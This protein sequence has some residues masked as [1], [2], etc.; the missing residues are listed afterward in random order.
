MIAEIAKDMRSFLLIV[1]FTIIG[2]SL[3]F[4]QFAS[5]T[6]DFGQFMLEQYLYLYGNQP[7]T[8]DFDTSQIIFFIIITLFLAL[9]LTNMLIALM[10]D[11]YNRVDGSSMMAD[12]LEKISLILEYATLKRQVLKFLRICFKRRL[13]NTSHKTR[14]ILL[15]VEEYR[16]GGSSLISEGGRLTVLEKKIDKL[17]QN[18]L[19]GIHEKM[20]D[21]IEQLDARLTRNV[22]EIRTDN[23][24]LLKNFDRIQ[25]LDQLDKLDNLKRLDTLPK[26][27]TLQKL[28]KLDKLDKIEK[29]DKID[30]LDKITNRFD[31]LDSIKNLDK[32]EKLSKLDKLDSLNR[33]DSLKRLDSLS[34]LDRLDQLDKLS[35]LSRLEKLDKMD[36]LYKLDLLQQLEKLDKLDQVKKLDNLNKLDAL[37]KLDKLE[38]LDGLGNLDGL[39]NLHLLENLKKLESLKDVK[40]LNE[41]DSKLD[42][43]LK[44]DQTRSKIW[45]SVNSKLDKLDKLDAI[46]DLSWLKKFEMSL[47]SD[48]GENVAAISSVQS[49]LDHILNVIAPGLNIP[50]LGKEESLGKVPLLSKKSIDDSKSKK[51][52][53]K[54]TI[55]KKL[56]IQEKLASPDMKEEELSKVTAKSIE[57]IRTE[58]KAPP[59]E[60]AE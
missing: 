32:L 14:R 44:L 51:K 17:A 57:K 23:N 22:K 8:N 21:Q 28:D 6:D 56:P 5:S 37:S 16:H 45:D 52:F 10:S 35:W 12:N 20:R 31:Q 1:L 42:Q 59:Q 11:T 19:P 27:E 26:L 48:K 55:P 25:L 13:S 49:K 50:T 36:L 40:W 39:K 33:L 9:I 58:G 60:E 47:D 53:G 34:N 29:L 24:E 7:D 38:K 54:K 4:Y 46:Q 2:F 43:S 18:I 15:V 3:I 30:R 41:L